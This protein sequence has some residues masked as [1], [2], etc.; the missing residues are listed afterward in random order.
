MAYGISITNASGII[1]ISESYQNYHLI[2]TGTTVNSSAL[3]SLTANQIL[4]VRATAFGHTLYGS[5]TAGA[6][7]K[8]T[9][10]S[11]A[12]A[13]I[14]QIPPAS[15]S[16]TGLRVYTPSGGISFDSGYMGIVPVSRT[17]LVSPYIGSTVS[18]ISMPTAPT[19]GRNRYLTSA[20]LRT[21][22]FA[23]AGDGY[24]S[25]V[26]SCKATFNS[27]LSISIT[28]SVENYDEIVGAVFDAYWGQTLIFGV[29]DA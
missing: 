9:G 4:L 6:S 3:P 24:T 21:T 22:G 13:I 15:S 7:V 14:N 18:T 25:Y 1:T 10:G 27:N 12:W 20:S 5:D 17:K 26:A 28:D 23:D 11:V 8:S 19:G 2:S 16:T 29:I